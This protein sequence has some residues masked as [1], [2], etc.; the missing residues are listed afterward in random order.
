MSKADLV[1]DIVLL[2]FGEEI[3]D[4]WLRKSDSKTGYYKVAHFVGF[5]VICSFSE[6]NNKLVSVKVVV[7]PFALVCPPFLKLKKV[8]IELS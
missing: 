8:P 5:G 1:F 4:V 7:N 6:M 2:E 3:I